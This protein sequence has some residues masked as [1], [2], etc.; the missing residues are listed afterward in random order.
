MS[1]P[2][3]ELGAASPAPSSD[4]SFPST[5]AASAIVDV[6][7]SVP[8]AVA[9]PA[10]PPALFKNPRKLSDEDLYK[11]RGGWVDVALMHITK[12]RIANPEIQFAGVSH[13]VIDDVI[14]RRNDNSRRLDAH[15]LSH[16]REAGKQARQYLELLKSQANLKG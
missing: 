2:S 5:S 13:G 16:L 14:A 6:L 11:G 8:A 4:A 12:A 9:T 7:P 3:A 10:D 1:D 15:E